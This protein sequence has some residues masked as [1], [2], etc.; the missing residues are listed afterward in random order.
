MVLAGVGAYAGIKLGYL[1]KD[2]GPVVKQTSNQNTKEEP[3]NNSN[4]TMTNNL[5]L[6]I[7]WL[8]TP[9]KLED[10]KLF[11]AANKDIFIS[12]VSYYK[13]ADLP[14]GRELITA[15][16]SS[17][18]ES[19]ARF[20]K[21][22]DGQYSFLE[23]NSD[24]SDISLVNAKVDEQTKIGSLLPPSFLEV[25][26]ALFKQG[27]W[28]FD[29]VIFGNSLQVKEGE[30]ISKIGTTLYGDIYKDV[31]DA[32]IKSGVVK[33][34]I[35]W[36]KLADTSRVPYVISI[37][38]LADDW[39]LIADFNK[40]EKSFYD[41]KFPVRISAGGCGFM[42]NLVND[43]V[44]IEN[45]NSLKEIGKTKDGIP[46]YTFT[47][48]DESEPILKEIFDASFMPENFSFND[49][50]ASEPVVLWQD[51]L[52]DY[53]IF[54]DGAYQSPAEMG[55]PVVY[56]Y[57]TRE[58]KVNVKVG[59]E[60]RQSEPIY[61]QGWQVTAYPD[62]RLINQDG[63]KYGSLFW[64]GMG[65]G[66]YP[67]IKQGRVVET[68][69]IEKEL[70][71]DL[72]KLG[73]NQKEAQEF[74]DFWLPRMPSTLY[75]RLSWLTTAELNK[76]APLAISPKPDTLIR[77]FL[78]FVGQDTPETNLLP[79]DLSSIKRDGFTVVEWGGLL[80]K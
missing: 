26:G 46:L 1:S 71:A 31:R 44:K 74:L 18:G 58:T 12:S 41:K 14:K 17:M 5:D 34:K 36:L 64:E 40:E 53:L 6:G 15:I 78:D 63:Q 75:T 11:K 2:N 22:A 45:K 49:F 3:K 32:L 8:V 59:A 29:S 27:D 76:L 7:K 24:W 50:V 21:D 23:K 42:P 9:Q 54:R 56:L 19:F 39:S 80:V 66:V 25:N 47:K 77:V 62:G 43:F 70:R 65:K 61:N 16:V 48:I 37:N 33:A 35:Y 60:I 68:K 30:N 28:C 69:N 79:Q 4:A 51:P 57:P 67:M 20:E 73:L 38:F 13:V 72:S 10:L 52:G 55:K